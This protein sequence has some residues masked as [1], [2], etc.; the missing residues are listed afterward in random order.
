MLIKKIVP[1]LCISLSLMILTLYILDIFNPGMD[2]VGNDIFKAI[3]AVFCIL[4][5]IT[6]FFL[7]MQNRKKS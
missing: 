7:V 5:L 4:T 3:M 6:S 1:H 2:L